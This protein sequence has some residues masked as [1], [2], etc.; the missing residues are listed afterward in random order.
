[1]NKTTIISILSSATILT[2][3]AAS[4]YASAASINP[5]PAPVSNVQTTYE[6][7]YPPTY[8][9]DDYEE[10][11]TTTIVIE[12]TTVRIQP[13][14]TLSECFAELNSTWLQD[15]PE[16]IHELEIEFIPAGI[17]DIIAE[18]EAAGKEYQ[19]SD[20]FNDLDNRNPIDN[21][22]CL[23]PEDSDLFN[24]LRDKY[25]YALGYAEKYYELIT[26][27]T[28][29]FCCENGIDPVCFIPSSLLSDHTVYIFVRCDAEKA[30]S[31]SELSEVKW[32]SVEEDSNSDDEPEP[33]TSAQ[34]KYIDPLIYKS[35]DKDPSGCR[36]Y[37]GND[38]YHEPI[39]H[40]EFYTIADLASYKLGNGYGSSA[41]Y[42]MLDLLLYREYGHI[43]DDVC[44]RY[45]I[46]TDSIISKRTF[47]AVAIL[48]REQITSLANDPDI[49]YLLYIPEPD[50]NESHS[51]TG[52]GIELTTAN[53]V[54]SAAGAGTYIK[55]DANCDGKVTVADCVAVLQYI[56]NKDKYP[57]SAD[58]IRNADIDGISG[59][60]GGDAIAI[61]KIDAGVATTARTP[62]EEF[63]DLLVADDPEFSDHGLIYAPDLKY[64][65]VLG[66]CNGKRDVLIIYGPK[67]PDDIEVK[68][69][70]Y[71]MYEEYSF[72]EWDSIFTK[73]Q[74]N[75]KDY[76][77]KN[78][79][80]VCFN[81]DILS[82]SPWNSAALKPDSGK[83]IRIAVFI[84]GLP[85]GKYHPPAGSEKWG[86]NEYKE[87][88]SEQDRIEI[89]TH[90]A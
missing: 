29:R 80:A 4:V 51:A 55:G 46:D 61:Q 24:S 60:T 52:V 84:E 1:M 42:E 44:R 53:T 23:Y 21:P 77:L 40:P 74:I 13:D 58:G 63:I 73:D 37:F 12:P 43:L 47:N 19:Q 34:E 87:Y 68:T 22:I 70:A 36:V 18:S 20:D 11:T 49:S 15:N 28:E 50:P 88:L 64:D 27:N 57:L 72:F 33:S 76:L 83:E 38:Y 31:L 3:A 9:V 35:L 32:L 30:L 6:A 8:P 90:Y 25:K 41:T 5:A 82:V 71:W 17:N 81:G 7:T 67:Y 78:D 69:E 39:A 79:G 59:I 56:A 2:S 66:A 14:Q 54:T 10:L 26:K 65:A 85:V 86:I 62:E 48:D 16:E 75:S 89:P 45:S